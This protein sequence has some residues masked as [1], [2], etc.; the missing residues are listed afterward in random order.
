MNI[1]INHLPQ[2]NLQSQAKP[3]MS[4]ADL[5]GSIEKLGASGE[6]EVGVVNSLI[7]D[8]ISNKA[9][10]TSST[11]HMT[12][13]TQYEQLL[14]NLFSAL[15]QIKHVTG[16]DNKYAPQIDAIKK[17]ITNN[18]SHYFNA[19]KETETI[20]F[21]QKTNQAYLNQSGI[22]S[23]ST[24]SIG[25]NQKPQ[26]NWT[27]NAFDKKL[28]LHD[29]VKDGNCGPDSEQKALSHAGI[30]NIPQ[31]AQGMRED[32]ITTCDNVSGFLKSAGIVIDAIKNN[33]IKQEQVNSLFTNLQS[34]FKSFDLCT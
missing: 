1:E 11:N 12:G 13:E 5:Q 10:L 9:L 21:H 25:Q 23:S 8:I 28:T 2:S 7:K 32:A 14:I 19:N 29:T 22:S 20:G 34:C 18:K 4:F 30:K 24:S 16:S 33:A 6:V 17:E 26:T 27:I 3:V 31:D 15:D